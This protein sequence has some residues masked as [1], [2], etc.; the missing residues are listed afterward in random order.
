MQALDRGLGD[1]SRC[2]G[3]H[4]MEVD[5]FNPHKKNDAIQ[6]YEDL[7]LASR[8][9]NGAKSD[10]WPTRKE[11]LSGMKFL[12]CCEEN[13]YG[14]HILEDPDTH[15]VVG[16]TPEG[17]YHVRHCELNAKHLVEERK[18]RAE[19][20]NMIENEAVTFKKG[21]VLPEAYDLLKKQAEKMVLKIPYLTGAALQKQRELEK[22]M[23]AVKQSQKT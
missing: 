19:L 5:H 18:E 16:V 8:H 22:A 7:F 10:T 13:D 12:N 1:S 11:R 21:P 23:T 4:S 20:W 3:S 9:C 14:V 15:K 6:N 2:N 17:R